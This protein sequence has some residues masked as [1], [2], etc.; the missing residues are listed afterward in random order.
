MRFEMRIENIQLHVS[1]THYIHSLTHCIHS[2][3]VFI[4][5]G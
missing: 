1:L 3:I 5:H 4:R 2:P